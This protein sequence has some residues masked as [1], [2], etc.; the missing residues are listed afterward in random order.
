M[1]ISIW[2]GSQVKV[3]TTQRD[4]SGIRDETKGRRNGADGWRWYSSECHAIASPAG[5]DH[6]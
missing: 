4:G 1:N 2:G 5:T 6:Q 3:T